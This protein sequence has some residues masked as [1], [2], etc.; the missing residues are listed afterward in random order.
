MGVGMGVGMGVTKQGARRGAAN[1]ARA[2]RRHHA[3][4]H[5]P[6]LGLLRKEVVEEEEQARR[7]EARAHGRGRRQLLAGAGRDVEAA[8]ALVEA[9]AEVLTLLL[10]DRR[11]RGQR[12]GRVCGAVPERE[13]AAAAERGQEQSLHRQAHELSSPRA[14]PSRDSWLDLSE[15]GAGVEVDGQIM[16]NYDL[17]GIT[18]MEKPPKFVK[19]YLQ[20]ASSIEEAIRSYVSEVKEKKFPGIEHSFK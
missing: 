10:G 9:V 8:V 12:R 6:E 5:V 20:G 1:R 3:A 13:H 2:R 4:R 19:N 16:V 11:G 18:Q 7:R 17:L 15:I 14:H